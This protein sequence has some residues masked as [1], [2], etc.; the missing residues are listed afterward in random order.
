MLTWPIFDNL[1]H[2]IASFFGTKSYFEA[3]DDSPSQHWMTGIL[4]F[5]TIVN[6]TIVNLF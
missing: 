2:V 3:E 5:A 4:G 6:L 1:C